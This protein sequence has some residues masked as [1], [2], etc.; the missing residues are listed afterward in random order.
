MKLNKIQNRFKEG[1]A[2]QSTRILG[3]QSAEFVQSK[4]QW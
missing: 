1:A 4:P 2:V 3:E